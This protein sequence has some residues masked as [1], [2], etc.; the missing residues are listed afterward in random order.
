LLLEPNNK[1]SD[2][3]VTLDAVNEISEVYPLSVFPDA[4]G[5][6]Q[7][8]LDNLLPYGNFAFNAFGP[9]NRLVTDE[10]ESIGSV[11][12]W[13]GEQCPREALKDSGFGA[14]IWQAADQRNITEDQAPLIVRSL[15]TAGV[16]SV[17]KIVKLEHAWRRLDGRNDDGFQVAPFPGRCDPVVGALALS[18]SHQLSRT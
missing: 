13:V 17:A 3:S 10:L 8:G 16:G 4:V 11:M 15:L 1:N 2:G 12:E 7:G 6:Q 5:L 14:D 18:L 9:R